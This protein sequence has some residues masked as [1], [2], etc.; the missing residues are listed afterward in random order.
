MYSY[1]YI[2]AVKILPTIEYVVV[3]V[4]TF[5]WNMRTVDTSYYLG[6]AVLFI[7]TQSK[8]SILVFFGPLYISVGGK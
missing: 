8:G 3:S 4:G 2:E 6:E 5:D 1:H 7:P